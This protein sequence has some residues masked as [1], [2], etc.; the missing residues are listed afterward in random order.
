MSSAVRIVQP[1]LGKQL[2]KM[3]FGGIGDK[4]KEQQAA[5]KPVEKPAAGAPPKPGERAPRGERLRSARR[6]ARQTGRRSLLS[7]SRLRRAD[8]SGDRQRTLG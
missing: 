6:R 1:A 7:A 2:T 4:L 3:K 5:E 8:E